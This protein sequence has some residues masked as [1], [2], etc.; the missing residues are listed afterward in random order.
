ML[1]HSP[2][3]GQFRRSPTRSSRRL[4]ATKTRLDAEA[5]VEGTVKRRHAEKQRHRGRT[6]GTANDGDSERWGRLA[7]T[8]PQKELKTGD[9]GHVRKVRERTQILEAREIQQ[10]P[11]AQ[12]RRRS[13]E[14][15]TADRPERTDRHIVR[16]DL[17][18]VSLSE[19]A[20]CFFSLYRCSQNRISR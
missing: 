8:R 20:R 18:L 15:Q 13:R 16:L 1:L 3:D 6:M 17:F 11:L 19:G 12:R 10:R 5:K 7:E 2:S 9:A 14:K 4:S